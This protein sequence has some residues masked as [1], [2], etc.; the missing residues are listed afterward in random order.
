MI[1]DLEI[2]RQTEISHYYYTTHISLNS[3]SRQT[4]KLHFTPF[5]LSE[6]KSC[7]VHFYIPLANWSVITTHRNGGEF[8]IINIIFNPFDELFE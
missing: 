2:T 1:G 4:R 6:L 8:H 7:V 5:N 3:D